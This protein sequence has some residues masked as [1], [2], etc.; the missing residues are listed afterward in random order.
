[1]SYAIHP[2]AVSVSAIKK[3]IGSRDARL[4]KELTRKFADEFAEID[5]LDEDAIPMERALSRLVMG[6]KLGESYG[7]KYG[8]ALK[9]LC[10]HL[11]NMLNNEH[12]SALGWEWIE[13][14]DSALA[15][16]GV[17]K[18]IFRVDPHLTT[19]GAPIPLPRIDDFPAIGYLLEAEMPKVL[20]EFAKFKDAE[21]EDEEVRDSISEMRTWLDRC[22]RTHKDLVCFYH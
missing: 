1:M 7:Y 15:E 10:E 2:Y 6:E 9:S 21:I 13:E 3:C 14:V 22:T 8:Y 17:D 11:G 19:R 12:R 18:K 5:E 4:V 20:M 16:L